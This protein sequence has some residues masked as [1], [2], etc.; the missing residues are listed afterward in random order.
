MRTR[1]YA[2]ALACA[3]TGGFAAVAGVNL[4]LDPEGV[5]G[6]NR[7]TSTANDRYLR[8]MDYEADPLAYG[9]VIFGSS[10]TAGIPPD[11]LSPYLGGA[12][13]ANFGVTAGTISDHL[14]VLEYVVRT[15]RSKP[16]RNAFLLL[17]L[18]L[19]A[20]SRTN[21]SIETL[22]PPGIT[23]ELAVQMA[24]PDCRP[25]GGLVAESSPAPPPRL[26]GDRRRSGSPCAP[27][28]GA[29]RSRCAG[30]ERATGP[31]HQTDRAAVV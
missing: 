28:R 7:A 6:L 21:R 22:L 8:F 16:V 14:P 29:G 3:V 1:T 10:R 23:G 19:F 5:F 9:A 12:R 15:R 18:D 25:T 11:L 4:S 24:I 27:F 26:G 30:T 2:I 20:E 13:V 31:S 17:D